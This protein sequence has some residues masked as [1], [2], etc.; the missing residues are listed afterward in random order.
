MTGSKVLGDG[1]LSP[2]ERRLKIV[3]TWN[4]SEAMEYWSNSDK[5]MSSFVDLTLHV[6]LSAPC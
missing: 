1:L 6:E 2:N 5:S 4:S 3:S